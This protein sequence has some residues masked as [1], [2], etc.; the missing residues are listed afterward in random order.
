MA[1]AADLLAVDTKVVERLSAPAERAAERR[2]ALPEKGR[3][4]PKSAG[5][6]AV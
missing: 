3:P 1:A 6:R 4:A 5:R 2:E